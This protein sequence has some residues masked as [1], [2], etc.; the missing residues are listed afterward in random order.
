MIYPWKALVSSF[1]PGQKILTWILKNYLYRLD[2]GKL[3]QYTTMLLLTASRNG[4]GAR[5]RSLVHIDI[6][7]MWP[8][9][10]TTRDRRGIIRC[11]LNIEQVAV[12]IPG[13]SDLGMYA[14]HLLNTRTC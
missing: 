11:T 12:S 7:G 14:C 13:E 10:S 8:P 2:T 6:C 4:S 5:I 9:K 1:L 3:F